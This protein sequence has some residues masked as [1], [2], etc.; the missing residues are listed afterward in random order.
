[1]WCESRNVV[2]KVPTPS[3]VIV[4][5]GTKLVPVIDIERF[6][7]GRT[8]VGETL[9]AAGAGPGGSV[10]VGEVVVVGTV[11]DVVV[12]TVVVVVGGNVVVVVVGGVATAIWNPPPEVAHPVVAVT[13]TCRAPA[14]C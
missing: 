6:S 13:P 3:M 4:A 5:P 14:R 9:E 7:P 2:A 12:G 11:V 10:V 8:R 1:M